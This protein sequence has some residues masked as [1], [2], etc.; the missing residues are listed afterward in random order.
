[1]SKALETKKK[2]MNLLKNKQMT[3]SEISR[4][5][6]LSTAT[7]SQHMDE[8][9]EMGAVEKVDN[10]YFKK[11]KYY[12]PTANP[13]IAVAK[14]VISAMVV[15]GAVCAVMLF[16][17]VPGRLGTTSPL[18]PNGINTTSAANSTANGTTPG[19]PTLGAAYACPMEFYSLNGTITGYKGFTLYYLNSSYGPVAD[20]LMASGSTASFNV[21]EKVTNL[22]DSNSS[23]DM[24]RTHY[25]SLSYMNS[26]FGAAA[27]G[28]NVTWTPQA[29][30]V[31]EN[32]TLRMLVDVA[33]N[34]TVSGTFWA[35][36]DGPCDGGVQPFLITV[37][38]KP[39]N[40]TVTQ[41][42]RV[43]A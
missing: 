29:Y 36:I 27:S 3:I 32:E 43:Y 17:G 22:L 37:G 1:M 33:A 7:I 20:Y 42:A 2:I 41:Q 30:N 4:E 25:A 18:Q 16:A 6:S 21:S 8:L 9:Q 23:L 24:N 34:S 5:L 13:S 10:E 31:S 26:T 40:G 14:Y 38:S 28:I 12:K 11:L 39:Y 35:R 19:V 15:I